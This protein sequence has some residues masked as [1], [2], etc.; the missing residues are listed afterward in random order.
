MKKQLLRF[1]LYAIIVYLTVGT[2]NPPIAA[3]HP[4]GGHETHFFG[5]IDGQRNKR[6][7][8]QFPNRNYARTF[9]ANLNVGEPYTVRLIYFLPSGR[10]PRP[11]ID[12]EMDALIKRVQ[13]F[14]AN[15]MEH[16]GFGRKTFRIETDATGKA[17]VHHVAGQFTAEYY[18]HSTFG[19]VIGEIREQFD[20]QKNIYLVVV[21]SGHLI[22]GTS[23][24]ATL[25]S[26]AGGV[27]MINRR[28]PLVGFYLAAHELGHTFGLGHDIRN[29]GYVMSYG[30]GSRLSYCAAEGLD[31]SRFFNSNQ[32]TFN[33]PTI[34]QMLPPNFASPPNAIRLR[35]EVTDVDGLYQARLLTPEVDSHGGLIACKRLNGTSSTVEF[36]TTELTPKNE[37]VFLRIID[38][39]GNISWSQSYPIDVTS[40]LPPPEV[41]SIPDTNLAATVRETLGLP[42]GIALTSHTMLNLITLNALNRQI[43]DLTGLEHSHHLRRLDLDS[44]KISNFS[45]LEGLTQLKILILRGSSLSDI[46]SLSDLT[47]L[48][49]LHLSDNSISDISSLSGLTQ[50]STLYLSDNSISDISSLSDTTE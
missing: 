3:S 48:S 50:L 32:T 1:T 7:A 21:D 38:V 40:L 4:L 46:S 13:Q 43:T 31:A 15:Q 6:Y 23:G 36:V 27:A 25:G 35:F 47:Q 37:S 49:T 28:F 26:G 29:D 45:S 16:H 9:A 11:N 39:H 18:E 8:A 34:V 14:C 10:E 30:S 42:P 12:A 41:V 24:L 19:K 5:V 33:E 44:N 2:L 20:T 17:V 22:N